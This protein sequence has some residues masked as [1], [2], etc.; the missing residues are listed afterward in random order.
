VGCPVTKKSAGEVSSARAGLGGRVF[1]GVAFVAENLYPVEEGPVA[2][3]V[4]AERV[5]G[6]A[7]GAAPFAVSDSFDV[8]FGEGTPSLAGK[9]G[10]G[11]LGH[12]AYVTP[13]LFTCV[14]MTVVATALA[15]LGCSQLRSVPGSVWRCVFMVGGLH[16]CMFPALP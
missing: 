6:G 4:G 15:S 5:G 16:G 8:G 3:V 13:G 9:V 10:A 14:R 12:C 7:S 1:P 11:T 2:Y